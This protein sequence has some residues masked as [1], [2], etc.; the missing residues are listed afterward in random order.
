[1]AG[2]L[3]FD[4]LAILGE[5]EDAT[6]K[7]EFLCF[8]HGPLSAQLGR[9]RQAQSVWDFYGLI[10]KSLIFLMIAVPLMPG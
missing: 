8:G 6:G 9:E 7:I 2:E 1:L 10:L 4:G 5:V 3:V